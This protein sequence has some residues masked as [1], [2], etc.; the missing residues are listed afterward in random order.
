[1]GTLGTDQEVG[2]LGRP[3]FED[4]RRLLAIRGYVFEFLAVLYATSQ[5]AIASQI[6]L[7]CVP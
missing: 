4:C 6:R 3:V 7:S 2:M 1:M 5:K